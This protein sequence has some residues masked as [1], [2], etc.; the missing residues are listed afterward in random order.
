MA[1]INTSSNSFQPWVNVYNEHTP[2]RVDIIQTSGSGATNGGIEVFADAGTANDFYLLSLDVSFTAVSA[3][4]LY[5]AYG[6]KS[7]IAHYPTCAAGAIASY[8]HN[9]PLGLNVGETTD[10]ATV[11]IVG[12]AGSSATVTFI[13]T[14]MRKA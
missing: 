7:V 8:S 1:L 9:Y 11:S 14:G 13:A 10:T 5:V 4:A 3:A 2:N 6:G 12:N